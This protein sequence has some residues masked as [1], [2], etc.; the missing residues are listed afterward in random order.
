MGSISITGIKDLPPRLRD[1]YG[2]RPTPWPVFVLA[3]AVCIAVATLGGLIAYRDANPDVVY[4]LLAYN[5]VD[6]SHTSV[7]FEVRRD[8][9][10]TVDCVLRAQDI[11]HQDVGYAIV[12]VPPG[13]DYVQ[14][15]YQLATRERAFTADVLACALPD[16]LHTDQP[17]FPPGTSN[18]P[19][20]WRPQ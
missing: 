16:D 7:T 8:G 2:Y 18:P 13:D 10:Q 9:S 14:Q 11:Q 4:K 17:A 5:T 20:P 3:A 15:T 19:Q 6:K 1:R 12:T